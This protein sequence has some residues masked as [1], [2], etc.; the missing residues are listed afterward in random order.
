MNRFIFQIRLLLCLNLIAIALPTLHAEPRCPASIAGVTPRF[1]RR[2]LVVIPVKVNH[3]GPFDFIVDTGTQITV[4][5]PSLA[6]E[7]SLE[8]QGTVGL[9]SAASCAHAAITVANTLEAA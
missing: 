2:A 8:P 4:V 5:H 1:V 7:L 6:S 9:V 3:A